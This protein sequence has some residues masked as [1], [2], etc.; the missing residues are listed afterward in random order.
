M[1]P[2]FWV[3]ALAAGL[4]LMVAPA[5]WCE[6]PETEVAPG[7]D[8]SCE[9]GEDVTPEPSPA[10][11]V[12]LED[13]AAFFKAIAGLSWRDPRPT[14]EE[15]RPIL[16]RCGRR[17]GEDF[18]RLFPCGSLLRAVVKEASPADEEWLWQWHDGLSSAPMLRENLIEAF[19]E[20]RLKQLANDLKPAEPP[21]RLPA[22]DDPAETPERLAQ[23]SPELL[24]AWRQYG[25]ALRAFPGHR[26]ADATRD[27]R[28]D[29]VA[30]QSHRPALWSSIAEYLRGRTTATEARTSLT[31]FVWTGMCGTGSES[32]T[33]ARSKAL[34][35]AALEERQYD[36]AVGEALR[37][38]RSRDA[39]ENREPLRAVIVAGGLDPGIFALGA[40]VGGD[41]SG[42]RDLAR[43][44]SSHVALPLLAARDLPQPSGARR[45]R[46]DDAYLSALAAFV[47]PTER[48]EDY[49]VLSSVDVERE[50]KE[51][52]P[53]GVQHSILDV[54]ARGVAPGA[55]LNEAE[56]AAH[57]L[58]RLCRDESRPAFRLMAES[59]YSRVRETGVIALRSLGEE[60]PTSG[61][62][63]GPVPLRITVDG[64]ALTGGTARFWLEAG[65]GSGRF[66]RSNE[67]EMGASGVVELERDFFVD[68]RAPIQ[69]VALS[70]TDVEK[71]GD[72]WF[73]VS[74]PPPS[75]LDAGLSFAVTTQSLTIAL[76]E[77]AALPPGTI[78]ML[79]GPNRT[80]PWEG[81]APL[82]RIFEKPLAGAGPV[83]FARL[84][85]GAYRVTLRAPGHVWR[86][87]EFE[88][89][90]APVTLTFPGD[91]QPAALGWVDG[92]LAAVRGA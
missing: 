84:Q 27:E 26:P 32:D 7:E 1:R 30:I 40:F 90:D 41:A 34:L 23:A 73:S 51:T 89:G 36:L 56:T 78:L 53:E 8:Q 13:D 47:T 11:I 14:N 50:A 24:E 62:R 33:R 69:R 52:V 18:D 86:S 9:V 85:R 37:L 66:G 81:D 21:L 92:R 63:A 43:H 87:R 75:D 15:L 31:R 64:R 67:V 22:A 46:E 83:V 29:D 61:R 10:E 3:C 17:A 54:L 79:E 20:R 72:L 76:G 28:P 70:A 35:A 4:S 39:D 60:L 45:W 71:P 25:A 59:A 42:L 77:T 48:C 2:T 44:G 57:L 49:R 82:T 19:L 16:E 91:F 38:Q 68:P 74:A 58:A 5:A 6:G 80:L 55:G 88:L 65:K 12:A